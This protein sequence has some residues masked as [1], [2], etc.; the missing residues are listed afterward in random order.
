MGLT[1]AAVHAAS[2]P[3]IASWIVAD[4]LAPRI[5]RCLLFGYVKVGNA[6]V[7]GGAGRSV[8]RKPEGEEAALERVSSSS[9]WMSVCTQVR[10]T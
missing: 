1:H 10:T 2:V 6:R 8:V 3:Q 4:E 7:Y 5:R 9:L